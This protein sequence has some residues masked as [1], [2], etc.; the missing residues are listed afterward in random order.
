MEKTR[1]EGRNIKEKALVAY[2]NGDSL[3]VFSLGTVQ[4]CHVLQYNLGMHILKLDR[5]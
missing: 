1:N 4:R 3:D 2:W 5:C